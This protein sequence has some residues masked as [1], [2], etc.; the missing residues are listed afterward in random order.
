MP[1]AI[2]RTV[3][4]TIHER[5]LRWAEQGLKSFVESLHDPEVQELYRRRK[6]GQPIVITYGPSQ[7]GKSTV[8]LQM[9]G[10]NPTSQNAKLVE[11]VLRG[12]RPRGDSATASAL[13][14]RVSPDNMWHMTF[15]GQRFDKDDNDQA[16]KFIGMIRA[17]IENRFEATDHPAQISIPRQ[18]VPKPEDCIIIDLPGLDS[19][20]DGEQLHVQAIMDRWFPVA[21]TILIV[22]ETK[23]IADLSRLV[24]KLHLN[25]QP[26][27]YRL[28][29]TRATS[30]NSESQ[31]L[32][33]NPKITLAKWQEHIRLI[34]QRT[35][36]EFPMKL[37]VFPFEVGD[38][39]RNLDA[40]LTESVKPLLEESEAAVRKGLDVTP[41]ALLA[42]QADYIGEVAERYK[43][44]EADRQRQI[45]ALDQAIEAIELVIEEHRVY[46]ADA[47]SRM[48]AAEKKKTQWE[49]A[50]VEIELDDFPSPPSDSDEIYPW[51]TANLVPWIDC[52]VKESFA[53]AYAKMPQESWKVPQHL[54]LE[55]QQFQLDLMVDLR[56]SFGLLGGW[57]AGSKGRLKKYCEITQRSLDE[58]GKK[59]QDEAE[60][61]AQ[62]HRTNVSK[63]AQRAS[64][65]L[66]LA[67]HLRQEKERKQLAMKEKREAA[68][69]E[70]VDRTAFE[71]AELKRIERFWHKLDQ[72]WLRQDERLCREFEGAH[73]RPLDQLFI[74]LERSLGAVAWKRLRGATT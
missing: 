22:L 24:Q 68:I 30:E 11:E 65:E 39:R 16:T 56:H 72:A 70:D 73:D 17:L 36:P 18:Y 50:K 25:T 23:N 61:E 43:Q 8:L 47:S 42:Q 63:L 14:Y 4:S 29:L 55:P 58:L 71:K 15:R 44:A 66:R 3:W 37:A 57:L 51:V 52:Q 35:V 54:W 6:Q 67:T 69:K 20:D 2:A 5:R 49:A 7:V 32:L 45:K 26:S 48:K 53:K 40:E 74:A 33:A 62:V 13:R 27:H 21:S 28:L 64:E 12:G 31:F 19:S 9:L 46:E 38:S 60:S 59:I 34:I 10:L 41:E 1:S